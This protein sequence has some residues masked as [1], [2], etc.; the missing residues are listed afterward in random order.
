MPRGFSSFPDEKHMVSL[1]FRKIFYFQ[2][3]MESR[4]CGRH[5]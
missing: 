2:L 1:E 3:K 5:F 4:A